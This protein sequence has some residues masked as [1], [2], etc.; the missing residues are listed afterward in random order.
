M[1]GKE[2]KFILYLS[3]FILKQMQ[4]F[5]NM[6]LMHVHSYEMS[7]FRVCFHLPLHTYKMSFF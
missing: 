4:E 2:R 5:R 7:R 3:A 1:H 6:D